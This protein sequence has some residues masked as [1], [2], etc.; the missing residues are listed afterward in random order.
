MFRLIAALII[1]AVVVFP[2]VA[3]AEVSGPRVITRHSVT[4]I[5]NNTY[6][7]MG[8]TPMLRGFLSFDGALSSSDDFATHPRVLPHVVVIERSVVEPLAV[9]GRGLAN[10]PVHPHLIEVFLFGE[11]QKG[12]TTIYLDPDVDY[13]HQGNLVLDRNHSINRAQRSARLHRA[14]GPLVIRGS[15]Y[16]PEAAVKVSPRFIIHKPGVIEP[17]FRPKKTNDLKMV[18]RG[19]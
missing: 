13:E 9:V 19:N 16:Q 8:R 5:P 4:T 7:Q 15:S 3:M 14:R 17:K 18:R 6:R 11:G 2:S 10:Q 12:S 1:V